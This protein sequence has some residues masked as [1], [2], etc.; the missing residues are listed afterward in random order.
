MPIYNFWYKK[1]I[2][3]ENLDLAL[4]QEKKKKPVFDSI[5]Q[6]DEP[7]VEQGTSAI[8]FKYYTNSDD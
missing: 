5:K 1:Q 8:G 2:K 6:I 7:T 4:R 3:A